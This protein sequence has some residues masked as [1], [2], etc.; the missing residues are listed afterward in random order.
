[1][2]L[3]MPDLRVFRITDLTLDDIKS[4]GVKCIILDVDNTLST[5]GGQIPLEGAVEWISLMAGNGY[6]MIIL[7]NNFKKRVAPLA[8]KFGL[9]FV[10]FAMKPFPFG[11]FRAAKKLGCKRRE[12]LA[13][14]DQIFTDVTGAHLAG[15]RAVRVDPISDENE[16]F[17]IRIRRALE[18]SVLK[19]YDKKG[20][21]R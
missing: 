2:R 4:F 16:D 7:S 21:H 17:T 1:M 8:E 18:K 3:F 11:F 5:H 19:R 15:I 12:M 9:E 14:G 10:S 20:R 6:K 13:I